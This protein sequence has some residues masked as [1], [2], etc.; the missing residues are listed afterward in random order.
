MERRP[1]GPTGRDGA[2]AAS[3]ARGA[4]GAPAMPDRS[5]IACGKGLLI[6][7][8]SAQH[9]RKS[10]AIVESFGPGGRMGGVPIGRH[11]VWLSCLVLGAASLVPRAVFATS[12]TWVGP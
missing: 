11:A 1:P 2:K 8:A 3:S 10:D 6:R 7:L 4:E 9:S 12:V 5:A